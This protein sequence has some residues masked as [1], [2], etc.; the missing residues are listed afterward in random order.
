[1]MP[2]LKSIRVHLVEEMNNEKEFIR[3][4]ADRNESKLSKLTRKQVED[5]VAEAVS[6]WK[7]K[8]KWKRAITKDDTLALRMIEQ[9]IN[10]KK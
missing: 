3:F 10:S 6:W 1:M 2:I 9:K 5:K 8:N 4:I 7:Y